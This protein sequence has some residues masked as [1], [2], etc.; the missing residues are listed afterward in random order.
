M[1][2]RMTAGGAGDSAAGFEPG[3]RAVVEAVWAPERTAVTVSLAG[4]RKT[5]PVV[6]RYFVLPHPS[7][8]RILLPADDVA[9]A[10]NALRAYRG[11]RTR[12]A[13]AW[14]RVIR[15]SVL[16]TSMSARALRV[17][18]VAA[19][20]GAE[21]LL[22]LLGLVSGNHQRL[23]ALFAVRRPEA[24]SKPTLGLVD[25]AG[26]P[27][28]YA[29]VGR[30]D[31]T[32]AMV[33]NEAATLRALAGRLPGLITPALVAETEWQ[34]HAVTVV[35]P[36]P[37]DAVRLE[38]EPLDMPDTLRAVAASGE[39]RHRELASSPYLHGLIRRIDA[40]SAS[41]PATGHVLADWAQRLVDQPGLLEFGRSHGDWV[42]WNLGTS[43]GRVVAWDWES[44]VPDAPL[45]I[46]ACHWY[47]QRARARAGFDSGIRAVE[48]VAPGLV[49]LGVPPEQTGRV[50]D[51]YL[52]N[53]LVIDAESGSSAG[54]DA[55]ASARA[56]GLVRRRTAR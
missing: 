4:S 51:L 15:G 27:V 44:S 10:R 25:G 5:G 2:D 32:D 3:L 38:T 21:R 26:R 40:L 39:L 36:L 22:P 30:S 23:R 55:G 56:T 17:L 28:A 13:E 35:S 43:A 46:D 48:E 8:A 16:S 34:G 1:T 12:R 6:E 49:K 9:S 31:L 19:L 37:A 54:A 42:S 50:A 53:T 11:L 24:V 29:K 45:G 47:F 52:L 20:P 7:R 14:S 33:R 41:R 18:T